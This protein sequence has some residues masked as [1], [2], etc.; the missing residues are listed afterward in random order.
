MKNREQFKEMLKN[1]IGLQDF[2]QALQE[3]EHRPASEEEIIDMLFEHFA[4]DE[5]DFADLKKIYEVE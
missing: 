2:I 3:M 4:E 5:Q 1:E